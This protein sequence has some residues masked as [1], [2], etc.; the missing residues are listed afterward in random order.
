V[1]PVFSPADSATWCA[2][3]TLAQV[4]AIYQLD[5]VT[6]QHRLKPSSKKPFVPM[7]YLRH[8]M[9]WRKV[10]VLRDVQGKRAA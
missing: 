8:P 5:P 2:T 9:R 7:P 1:T 3:L 4:A 10:D 6:L